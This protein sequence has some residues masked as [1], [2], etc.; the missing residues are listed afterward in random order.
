M[1]ESARSTPPRMIVTMATLQGL[2]KNRVPQPLGRRNNPGNHAAAM[3][4]GYRC[5]AIHL[6][7]E[8]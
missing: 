2:L 1:M 7:R 6:R 8:A 4:R 3:G 5:Y